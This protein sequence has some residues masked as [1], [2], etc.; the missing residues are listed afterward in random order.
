MQQNSETTQ[1]AIYEN[2]H[3]S[4]SQSGNALLDGKLLDIEAHRSFA[5]LGMSVSLGALALSAFGMKNKT[6]KKIHIVAG[7]T[8]VG[9]SLYHAGLYD[10]GIFKRL[11]LQKRKEL[12]KSQEAKTEEAK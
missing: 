3:T 5:K 8:M 12:R 11:I 4:A 10:G 2:D 1:P 9:F 7:V 6:I